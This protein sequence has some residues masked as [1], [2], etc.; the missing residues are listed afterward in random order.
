MNNTTVLALFLCLCTSTTLAQHEQLSY[1]KAESRNTRLSVD[2]LQL[3]AAYRQH[4]TQRGAIHSFQ[5]HN[6]TISYDEGLVQVEVIV[7]GA[8]SGLI[9]EA[10]TLGMTNIYT[11]QRVLNGTIPM[12]KL[13]QLVRLSGIISINPV[14]AHVANVGKAETQGHLAQKTQKVRSLFGLDG[15]GIKVGVLSDSYNSLG[16]AAAGVAS[17]DLPGVNN[18]YGYTL[19]VDVLA[20]HGT[21]DEGRAMLE[22]IHDIAPGAE[23]A[24]HTA[25]GGSAA[26]AQGIIDLANV[27]DCDI[28]VDD[29]IYRSSP[30]FQDGVIAQ[31]VDSVHAMGITY[32]TSAGNQGENAY[33]SAFQEGELYHMEFTDIYGR[34]YS[35]DLIPHEFAPGDALQ[36]I[37]IPR[38]TTLILA[39]QWADRY[40]SISGLPGPES[41]IDF[42]LLSADGEKVL[43]SS[44]NNNTYSDPLEM[45]SYTNNTVADL[46]ANLMIGL[47]SG[48]LPSMMKYVSYGSMWADEYLE[49]AASCIGHAN[50]AGAITVGAAGYHNTPEFG[51]ESPTLQSFSSRGGTPVFYAAET[52]RSASGIVRNKPDIIAPDGGDNTFFG[53]DSDGNGLPNFFGTSAAAPHAAGLAALLLELNRDLRPNDIREVL[54]RTTTDMEA[55]GFDYQSGWGLID[56]FAATLQEAQFAPD[57]FFADSNEL[58]PEKEFVGNGQ[59]NTNMKVSS[60]FKLRSAT[61]VRLMPGFKVKR[62]TSFSA[63]VDRNVKVD[64][65][66]E[67]NDGYRTLELRAVPQTPFFATTEPQTQQGELMAFPSPFR[68]TTTISLETPNEQQVRLQ[69]MNA[70]GQLVSEVY[71]GLLPS[72]LNSFTFNGQTLPS[73]LYYV[74][75]ER[76]GQKETL[77]I[78][79]Q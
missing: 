73:G 8:A 57:V 34:A 16:G 21:T 56:G 32:F 67:K 79:K 3:Q 45:L 69:V 59:L 10:H 24:F 30:F 42:F 28:I 41:D 27:A 43:A 26:F 51:V 2:L 20:D 15:S 17:G 39:L 75:L 63:T 54:Q 37:R 65:P 1:W 18:P 77:P 61:S 52:N 53:A 19:P 22:I 76:N 64:R 31:A 58:F 9:D 14:Y 12:Q 23:L 33:E 46:S 13:D 50:A 60:D 11:F 48:P 36:A 74:V 25:K 66:E 47:V 6:H 40:T 70:A 4:Q 29:I 71:S 78:V 49:G 35:N 68:Q 72:G 5:P 44:A 38:G 7:D 55:N 62:G